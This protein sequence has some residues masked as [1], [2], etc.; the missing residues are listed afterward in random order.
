MGENAAPSWLPDWKEENAYTDHGDDLRSWAWEFLRRNPEYQNDYAKWSSL[1]DTE[2]DENGV[3]GTTPKYWR[4]TGDWES[5][6]YFQPVDGF[7]VRDCETLGEY[8]GRTG[9]DPELLETYLCRRWG[10]SPGLFDPALSAAPSSID[11][12]FMPPYFVQ[13][14]EKYLDCGPREKLY[15]GSYEWISGRL[16]TAPWPEEIDHAV[17]CLAFDLRFPI[18]AQIDAAYKLLLEIEKQK[19]DSEYSDEI[20]KQKR[21][22]QHVKL[23]L[24]RLRA[25]DAWSSGATDEEM[26]LELYDKD[27]KKAGSP[28]D[29]HD[30]NETW[31]NAGK[32]W[33]GRRLNEA[34]NL[35][36]K[37][38]VDLLKWDCL[39]DK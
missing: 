31:M 14:T 20:V 19:S 17:E 34:K 25:F 13:F 2:I 22:G 1:P 23:M 24:V 33:I 21:P 38:Y 10:I 27:P 36:T 7:P 12:E 18:K 30:F 6:I 5:M 11:E 28:L 32:Q 8:R 29:A 26:C 37:G 3:S 4:A 35:S 9:Q 15:G 16:M 39:P